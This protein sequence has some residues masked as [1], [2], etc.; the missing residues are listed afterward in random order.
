MQEKKKKKLCYSKIASAF[1]SEDYGGEECK[2]W[3]GFWSAEIFFLGVSESQAKGN[4]GDSVEN[5][6]KLNLQIT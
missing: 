1:S 6:H 4:H 3:N 2:Y 5:L